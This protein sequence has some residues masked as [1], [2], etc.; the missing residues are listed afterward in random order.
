ME[1]VPRALLRHHRAAPLV[2][3]A[4]GAAAGAG[5]GADPGAGAGAT[6][7]PPSRMRR[8]S[9]HTGPACRVQRPGGQ[10]TGPGTLSEGSAGPGPGA[11]AATP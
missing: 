8:G 7:R 3:E 9:C 4:R 1:L 11:P 6:C 10:G 5:S 2:V